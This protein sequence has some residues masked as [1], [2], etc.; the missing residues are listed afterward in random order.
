[1]QRFGNIGSGVYR[2]F[3]ETIPPI[4]RVSGEA[5]RRTKNNTL[6]LFI[7]S[8]FVIAFVYTFYTNIPVPV[9]EPSAE[10]ILASEQSHKPHPKKTRIPY[11][12]NCTTTNQTQ[13]CPKNLPLVEQEPQSPSSTCPDYFR[14]IHE[15]LRPW[16]EKGI[17]KEMV[18]SARRTANFRLVILSGKAYVEIYEKSP[19]DAFTLW[20]I[21]QLLKLYPKQLPDLDLMFD[22]VDW[23]V[24]R[25]G[26]YSGPNATAPPPLFRYC[27]DDQSLDIVFP[28]WTFWGWP[29]INI[30]PWNSL[31][32][33]IKEESNKVNW[34]EREPYAYW[35]GN[36]S[37]AKTRQDLLTCNV[38]D[39]KD[40]GAR[41][42]AQ[43]WGAEFQKG[44]KQSNLADQCI[45][46]YKIYIEGSAWSV[47]EKY[48]LACDSVT[49]L[50]RPQ[51]YNTFTRGLVPVHHYW[52]IKDNDKC[53]SIK[54]AVQWGNSHKKKAQEIGK[55]SSNF[56]HD[57]LTMEYVY[58][59][60]FHLL[61]EY[62]KLLKYKPTK[63]ENAIEFCSETM[64]C[65]ADG[66]ARKFMEEAM[67]RSPSD[68]MPCNFP[69]PMDP[70][71]RLS[72]IRR[73][74]N[75]IKQVEKWEKKYW[76]DQ[77]E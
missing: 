3:S 71:T 48:I 68:T 1:M 60:M 14:W 31:L 75:S 19:R 13:T 9:N 38:S 46:R 12:L 44:F 11:S 45:H 43:D 66:T 67:V 24:I 73:N 39:K 18:E 42:Y 59:Y 27:S 69:P 20:G 22:C 62:A 5:I 23:P 4:K 40:W 49:L 37:V 64:A 52:P 30:K 77:T 54:F 74:V 16:K 21:L 33:E 7:F 17:T 57:N 8:L 65:T 28:D 63:P 70:L 29:E 76:D 53:R 35:K 26:F 36:P 47:S 55:A 41:L 56:I 2:H 6:F 32:K 61:N 72:L 25:K 51:Y 50:V 15:D 34:T 58:D 10:S